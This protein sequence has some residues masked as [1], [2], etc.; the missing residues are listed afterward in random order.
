MTR[1]MLWLAVI[2]LASL[3]AVLTLM[4]ALRG[5]FRLGFGGLACAA[6]CVLPALMLETGWEPLLAG[7][8]GLALLAAVTGKG[9]CG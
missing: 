2:L 8:L 9:R 4:G 1:S 5:S 7:A 3:S 6:A